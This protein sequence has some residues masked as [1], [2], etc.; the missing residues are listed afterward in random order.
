MS[1]P[2]RNNIG[3]IL[4]EDGKQKDVQCAP[5]ANFLHTFP[6]KAIIPHMVHKAGYII[7]YRG[8][9]DSPWNRV[10]QDFQ[11]LQELFSWFVDHLQVVVIEYRFSK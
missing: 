5:A 10:Y 4:F 9:E 1:E 11:N 2:I 3:Y 7:F 6:M 8:K